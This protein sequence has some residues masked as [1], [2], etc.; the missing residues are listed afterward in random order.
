MNHRGR[1]VL[2]RK[3]GTEHGEAAEYQPD[4]KKQIQEEEENNPPATE[5]TRKEVTRHHANQTRAQGWRREDRAD[6]GVRSRRKTSWSGSGK[7]GRPSRLEVQAPGI[8]LHNVDK[9]NVTSRAEEK[10]LETSRASAFDATHGPRW[11]ARE[12]LR[13]RANPFTSSPGPNCQPLARAEWV[14]ARDRGPIGDFGLLLRRT[15]Q[16]DGSYVRTTLGPACRSASARSSR[17]SRIR[18]AC[19]VGLR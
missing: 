18:L 13:P 15:G 7:T 12:P 4:Y 2:T 9:D 14:D 1:I 6:P 10:R 16:S 5:A 17:I 8:V 19:L 11:S 3:R